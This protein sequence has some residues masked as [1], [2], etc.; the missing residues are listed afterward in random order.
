MCIKKRVSSYCKHVSAPPTW[1]EMCRESSLVV[2]QEDAI[3]RT[4]RDVKARAPLPIYSDS[5]CCFPAAGRLWLVVV[6][7][8]VSLDIQHTRRTR[9]KALDVCLAWEFGLRRI[10]WILFLESCSLERNF[11]KLCSLLS[12]SSNEVMPIWNVA[13]LVCVSIALLLCQACG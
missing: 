8:V 12:C 10:P 11:W 7:R 6:V 1:S 3:Q 9:R 4:E 2:L 13:E 5:Y